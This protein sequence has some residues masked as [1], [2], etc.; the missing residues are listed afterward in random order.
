[1]KGQK[2]SVTTCI[3]C[4]V[5][6]SAWTA[7]WWGP[8]GLY[9][10]T[11]FLTSHTQPSR[12]IP[13]SKT[14]ELGPGEV[15]PTCRL[16]SDSW[17]PKVQMKPGNIG[18]DKLLRRDSYDLQLT[19][20]IVR[21]KTST[22]PMVSDWCCWNKKLLT[23]AIPLAVLPTSGNG[24]EPVSLKL[25]LGAKRPGFTNQGAFG[26]SPHVLGP[27]FPHQNTDNAKWCLSFVI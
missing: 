1:M 23:H 15:K 11:P 4:D 24:G 6:T 18:C 21:H 22:S 27:Q 3:V 25:G 7:S 5:L 8:C 16:G 17:N 19:I 9:I 2:H 10:Y 12:Q 13:I 20:E 26:K 14:N